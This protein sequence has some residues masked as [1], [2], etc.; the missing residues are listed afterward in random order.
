M[1][2]LEHLTQEHRKVE[3]LFGQLSEADK[4]ERA[5]LVDELEQALSVH[6]AVEE[7]HLY[8]IVEQIAGDEAEEEAETEHDLAREGIARLRAMVDKPGFGAVVDMVSAG[9]R[10]HVQ[11]EE[12]EIFPELRRKAAERIDRLDPEQLEADVKA[13]GA[14]G[15]S[16]PP[17]GDGPTKSELYQQAQDAEIEGR[18][19]MTKD[20]LRTALAEQR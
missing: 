13:S 11:E 19:S 20:E 18:S 3:Q 10:H 1:D 4:A 8:P 16:E 5:G 15:R 6:M 7:Q 14:T 9:I 12:N 17:S 2:V